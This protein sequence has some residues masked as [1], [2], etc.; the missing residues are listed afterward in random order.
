MSNPLDH[1]PGFE[2]GDVVPAE[3]WEEPVP[4]GT[5]Q[6]LPAFPTDV[7][8][9]YIA[10]MVRGVAEEVQVP[11]DLP[12]GLALAVLATAAG[13]RAEVE[14]RGQ[15]REPL[16]LMVAIAMPPGSGKS[17]AFRSMLGPVFAAETALKETVEEKV[18]EVAREKRKALARAEAA[19]KKAKNPDEVETAVDA[20]GMAEE[21]EIP[22]LPRLSADDIT[23]EAAATLLAEQGGRLAILS[24]EGTFFEV[25]MGRYTNGHPNLELVLK[26]HAG[27]RLVI[28]RR[29][30]K[31][32]VERPALTMGICLQ[33]Q[34][35]RDIAAK[36]QMHGRGALARVLFAV[37]PDMVGWRKLSPDLLDQEVLDRYRDTVMGLVIGL[38]HW[39]DPAV[40]S[41]TPGAL[42]LHTEWRAEIEPRLR[43]GSGDLE[44]LQEW[45]AKLLG[46]TVR[47]AGLLHLADN[48]TQG[49]QTAISEVIMSRAIE[50][51]RYYTEHAMAAYGVMR[52]H[53]RLEDAQAV[54]TWIG[55]R[56]DFTQREAHRG[57]HRKFKTAADLTAV[58]A[59]LE[60][61]GYIR[62]K[63]EPSTGGR[64][65]TRYEANSKGW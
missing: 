42:K 6:A 39:T 29:G 32:F 7:F 2:A 60:D 34:L 31:E 18:K 36:K 22:V 65:P 17:P 56:K 30:R 57:M 4:L 14:V 41:L 10:E 53:P 63:V 9:D 8:P 62:R 26:G 37:P 58:L 50:L 54:L 49:V 52:A 43:R 23:P 13:G 45:A 1:V 38:S 48:P 19:R 3:G 40:L 44:N 59:L 21:M 24:A 27:D 55:E 20:A 35:L 51:A 11:E 61:H 25:I 47:L 16:N 15:W 28:D 64:K 33:P 46:H 5:R 12:G